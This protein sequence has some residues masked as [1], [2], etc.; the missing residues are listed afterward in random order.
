MKILF[1]YATGE[2]IRYATDDEYA[3]S[4]AAAEIDGGAGVIEVDGISCFVA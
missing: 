3:A 2:K 1:N 4:L